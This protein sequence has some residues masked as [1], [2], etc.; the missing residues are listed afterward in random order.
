M[1]FPADD[2]TIIS[3]QTLPSQIQFAE[4]K[5]SQP[6]QSVFAVA[7]QESQFVSRTPAQT[8][9]PAGFLS[10][11]STKQRFPPGYTPAGVTRNYQAPKLSMGRYSGPKTVLYI[12]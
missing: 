1:G 4:H 2:P 3:A 5:Q 10:G 6:N 12:F 8:D 7:A 11:V 9:S